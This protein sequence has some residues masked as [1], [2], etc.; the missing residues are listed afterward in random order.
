[1]RLTS[2]TLGILLA[3]HLAVAVGIEPSRNAGL[4]VHMLPKSVADRDPTGTFKWGFMVTE[5]QDQRSP[6]ERPVYQKAEELLVFL[7]SRPTSVQ[8]NG[9]WVVVTNPDA[10]A[11]EEKQLLDQLKALCLKEKVPLFLCRGSELPNG[12]KRIS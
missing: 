10:Y 9:I 11:P 7:K 6:A 4:S 2:F 12:W 8:Q 3:A 5:P 1:M